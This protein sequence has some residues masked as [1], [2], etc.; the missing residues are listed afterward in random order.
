MAKKQTQGEIAKK[1]GV[2]QASIA[3]LEKRSDVMLST[4]RNYIEAM[5]GKLE[6]LVEFPDSKPITITKLG[7]TEELSRQKG[8]AA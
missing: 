8:E 7:D 3:K 6:L 5:G 4:L 1:L 2:R